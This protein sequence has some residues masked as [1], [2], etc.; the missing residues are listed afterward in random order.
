MISWSIDLHGVTV[1]ILA[2]P[3][4]IIDFSSVD[5]PTQ[6]VRITYTLVLV[7]TNFSMPEIC[8]PDHVVIDYAI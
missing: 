6:S 3:Y 4:N 8:P 1:F 5:Y 7:P 2:Q